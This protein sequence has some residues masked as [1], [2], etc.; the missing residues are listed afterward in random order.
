MKVKRLIL[1]LFSI[2]T[3]YSCSKTEVSPSQN[4]ITPP[5]IPKYSNLIDFQIKGTSESVYLKYR[6]ETGTYT[7]KDNFKPPFGVQF[8]S[9]NFDTAKFEV[10]N[11]YS[12]GTIVVNVYVKDTL[13]KTIESTAPKGKIFFEYYTKNG[14]S[15]GYQSAPSSWNCG[16]YNGKVVYT[17]PL[18]G[19]YYINSN[20][21]K[22]YVDRSYCSCK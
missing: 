15:F 14:K 11:L 9:Y 19:C 21:N 6:N 3:F 12:T 17:G 10:E 13:V 7:E 1:A 20:G 8:K 18:G 2:T 16:I 22:T 4:N 5:S